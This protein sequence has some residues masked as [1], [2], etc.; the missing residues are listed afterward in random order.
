MGEEK[1]AEEQGLSGVAER[2]ERLP[3]M[4]QMPMGTSSD[5]VPCFGAT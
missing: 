4:L 3:M 2:T 5:E 1:R